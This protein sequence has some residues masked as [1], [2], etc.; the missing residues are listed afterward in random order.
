MSVPPEQIVPAALAV[1]GV[2]GL[3][4]VF[5]G[6]AWFGCVGVGVCAGVVSTELEVLGSLSPSFVAAI[7][8]L[9]VF[10]VVAVGGTGEPAVNK[11]ITNSSRKFPATESYGTEVVDPRRSYPEYDRS[12]EL[13]SFERVC[14][15]LISEVVAEL[16]KTC[17]MPVVEVGKIKK[18]LEY[19][20]KGGK[21]NRGLMVVAT[22]AELLK[23]KGQ[24]VGSDVL[25]QLAILGWCVEWLQ[26]WLLI[27][28]DIM[29]DS[30][31]RRGQPCWYRQPDIK[32]AGI[33]D[34]FMLE[35]LVFRILKRHFK[36]EPFYDQLVDLFMETAFQTECGQFADIL[37][38]NMDIDKFDLDRWSYIVKYKTAF[39]SF[40]CPVA[41]GMIITGS[42]DQRAFDAIREPLVK[43]GVYFQ[44]T[45]D[46]LDCF[47]TPEQIGKIGTDIQDKKCGWLFVHAYHTLATP[48]QR[49]YLDEHYGKCKVGSE[50]E[51]SIK[52]LYADLGVEDLYKKYEEESFAEIM[53][54]RPSVEAAGLPWSV[55]ETFLK[56]IYKRSK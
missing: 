23:S 44:A 25:N 49:S 18:M 6:K 27:A 34:A 35:N 20:T 16:P 17:E 24:P 53:T 3:A 48:E 32:L 10:A 8:G 11:P 14:D 56:K 46:F 5:R 39:Y 54:S 38:D 51:A 40:Y 42:H 13:Q 37:C 55:V 29:D 36:N 9:V 28:D 31:T 33:N 19:N 50:E 12:S 30:I 43:M 1:I 21:M 7:A 26:A 15:C 45:D 22:G 47:G 41:L 4:L 52:K 2:F